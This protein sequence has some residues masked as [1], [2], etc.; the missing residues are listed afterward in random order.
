MDTAV[1]TP[2]LKFQPQYIPIGKEYSL[3]SPPLGQAKCSSCNVRENCLPRGLNTEEAH[4]VDHLVQVR[5]RVKRGASLYRTGDPFKSLYAVRSGFFKTCVIA[6]DGREQ[7]TCLQM[8]GD[9]MGMDGI[10]T[11]FHNS[12]VVALEDSEVCVIHIGRIDDI[13]VVV[14]KLHHEL[15]RMMSR[16]IV[17]DQRTMTMLGTMRAEERVA[18]FLLNLSQRFSM[19]GY[20]SSEF[21]LRMTRDEIGN[22]LGLTLETIS[23]IFSKFQQYGLLTVHNKHIHILDRNR[24]KSI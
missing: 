16:E 17:R 20:S 3:G 24:L 10:E 18:T 2:H 19:L 8:P 1:A 7:I 5:I 6:E 13:S 14:P 9:F 4:H 12:N 23:R 22:Y 11:E 21:Y 15:N